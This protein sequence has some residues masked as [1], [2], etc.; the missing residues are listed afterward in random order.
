MN[1]ER[2]IELADHIDRSTVPGLGFNLAAWVYNRNV[3]SSIGLPDHSGHGCGTTACIAG[4]A[5]ALYGAAGEVLN[6]TD[7]DVLDGGLRRVSTART[8]FRKSGGSYR[9]RGQQLLGLSE[10]QACDLFGLNGTP[11]RNDNVTK[12]QAVATLLHLAKTGK[13]DWQVDP[14]MYP[15]HNSKNTNAKAP[16][17]TTV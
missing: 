16:L 13:V 3:N 6:P 12:E 8:A 14:A 4:W 10:L 9:E 15:R 17:N 5:V 7:Q 1:V 11:Q 2:I